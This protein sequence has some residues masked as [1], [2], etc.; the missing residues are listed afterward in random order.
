[1]MTAK[2]IKAHYDLSAEEE[3]LLGELAPVMKNHR[4][5]FGTEM[6]SWRSE[7]GSFSRKSCRCSSSHSP[8]CHLP[9]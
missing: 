8:Q 4:D 5:R 9:K 6:M 7:P 3:K 1:M 2:K